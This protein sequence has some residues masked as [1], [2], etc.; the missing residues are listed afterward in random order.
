MADVLLASLFRRFRSNSSLTLCT[1]GTSEAFCISSVTCCLSV[2]RHAP[3]KC[4]CR[5]PSHVGAVSPFLA[6]CCPCFP[7]IGDTFHIYEEIQ[8]RVSTDAAIKRHWQRFLVP[9][10][11]WSSSKLLLTHTYSAS[12]RVSSVNTC[13]ARRVRERNEVR[14]LLFPFFAP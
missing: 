9:R 11:C 7:F 12:C 10:C 14:V 2:E 6:T 8:A 4:V 1:E 3:R 5:S 13:L